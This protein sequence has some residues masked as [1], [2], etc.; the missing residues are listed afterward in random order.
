MKK[1]CYFT[2]T[3]DIPPRDAVYLEGLKQNGIEIIECKDSSRSWRKFI[4]LYKKH[5]LIRNEYDVLFVGYSAHTIVPF[6]RLISTRKVIFNAL[7]S[8]YEGIILSRKQYG[9]LGLNA[10]YCLAV[11]F[12]AFHS[13]SLNLVET[14]KQ[15]EYLKKKFFIPDN[16]LIRAF[17]GVN[18]NIFFYDP[19]IKKLADFT[20]LFRGKMLPESGVEYAVEA[21]R[22]FQN[23]GTNIKLR[24]IGNGIMAEKVSKLIKD[25][26]LKN[27]EWLSEKLTNDVLRIKM[28][29]CHLSLGQLSNHERLERTTP[30]K[31]FECTSMRIPY[32]TARNEGIAELLKENED[33]FCCNPADA[34]ELADKILE[35]KK[36][37]E[38]LEK[39]ADNAYQLYLKELTPKILAKRVLDAI[40][41]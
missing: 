36:N 37:P 15:K 7:G 11:D 34:Q 22:I 28:Q 41:A 16:K 27:I 25:Y 17:T 5:R 18:E 38:L 2:L 3:K 40:D 39:V 35:L 12:L 24:I 32:L 31:S 29:E 26:R 19:D 30:H 1:I 21:A 14:N 4:A 9:F 10:L 13:A 6:A 20:V 8:L 23:S 33:C